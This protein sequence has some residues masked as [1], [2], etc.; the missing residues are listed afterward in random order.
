MDGLSL[1][2]FLA[3]TFL[4]GVTSGLSGFAM[5]LVVSGVWLH[6]ITPQQNALLIVLCGL[7]TQGSG[8]WKVR[9]AISWRAVTPFII[10]GLL[11]VPAG[12]ALLKTVE[13]GTLRPS[14]GVLLVIYSLYSLFRPAL[15]P[16]QGGVAAD[17][18]VGIV[19]G[20]VGG[21]TGLGGVVVTI[22]CQLRGGSKDAQRAVF[23]PVLFA[24]FVT[25]AITYAFAGAY[26]VATLKLYAF[27]LPVLG[28]AIWF[29]FRLYGKLDDAAFRKLILLILL[30]MGVTL[31]APVR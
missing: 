13:Q 4:G 6:I 11:G 14:I 7:V 29:G 17:F 25:S 12:T 5:G 1:A 21:L 20:F 3:A 10:G 24:T 18:G 2:F 9:H 16:V 27:A 31:I 19:N 15:K 8:I 26:N 30:V 28:V 23:Q 22:W